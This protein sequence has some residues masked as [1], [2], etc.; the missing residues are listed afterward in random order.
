[1][2]R[3]LLISALIAVVLTLA[4]Q[5][6]RMSHPS[7]HGF[8]SNGATWNQYGGAWQLSDGVMWNVSTERGAKLLTGNSHWSN[9]RVEA[10]V[11]LVGSNG[12]AG[13]IVR[14]QNPERGVDSY[15]GYF[16][17]L[18]TLDNTMILGRADYGWKE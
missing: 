11:A 3:S 7:I 15:E 5:V 13:I 6:Q 14:A 16:A 17:G 1:M 18:R 8:S 2:R 4:F 12:D 9:Y 10:D